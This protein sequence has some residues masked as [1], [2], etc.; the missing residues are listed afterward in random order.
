[1]QIAPIVPSS[2]A[3]KVPAQIVFDEF[4]HDLYALQGRTRIGWSRD[5]PN[6][7]HMTFDNEGFRRLADNV[8]QDTIDGVKLVLDVREGGDTTVP[9]W[10][11]SSTSMINAVRAMDG[12]TTTS[13]YREHGQ[14]WITFNT[15]DKATT[16]RLRRLVNPQLADYHVSWNPWGVAAR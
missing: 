8:L 12:V 13:T 15:T 11:E 6:E 14:Y 5:V 16:A 7:I 1:M 4:S 3:D 9:W 10:S 2:A